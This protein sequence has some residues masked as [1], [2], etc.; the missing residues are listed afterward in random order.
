MATGEI[1]N[2]TRAF[3]KMSFED[4]Q[5]LA[6]QPAPFQPEPQPEPE[7]EPQRA[8]SS[9]FEEPAP[10]SV[11]P[12]AAEEV[13]FEAPVEPEISSPPAAALSGDIPD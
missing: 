5:Q 7:P 10:V 9:V 11:F 3:T 12:A 4:L 6:P 8:D 13:P 1:Q 2:E